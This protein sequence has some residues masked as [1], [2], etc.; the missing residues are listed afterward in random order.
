MLNARYSSYFI[1]QIKFKSQKLKVYISIIY[2]RIKEPVD[3]ILELFLST[4][5]KY[6]YSQQKS[7]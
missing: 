3:E 1:I 5:K 2:F 4:L 6:I 7:V